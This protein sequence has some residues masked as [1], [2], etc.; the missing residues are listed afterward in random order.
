MLF[1]FVLASN[2]LEKCEAKIANLC[3]QVLQIEM[4]LSNGKH[5]RFMPSEWETESGKLYPQTR[6]VSGECNENP[7]ADESKWQWGPCSELG[8]DLSFED[9]WFS[10]R[11]GG[12]GTYG[13]VTSAYYQLHD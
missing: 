3:R 2:R 5:V 4:V 9:L 6:K 7:V 13:V 8:L 1:K 11:G 12:G 10:V